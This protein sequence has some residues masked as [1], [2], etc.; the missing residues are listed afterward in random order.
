MRR[1]YFFEMKTNHYTTLGVGSNATL[2]DIKS[3]YRKLAKKYHP[4][5]AGNQDKEDLEIFNE[6]GKAYEILSNPDKRRQYDA[7]QSNA[8]VTDMQAVASDIVAEYF[9]QFSQTK[10]THG[11]QDTTDGSS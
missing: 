4:D 9:S 11:T 5:V 3:V 8:P 7:E 6:I 1:R 10:T 2:D